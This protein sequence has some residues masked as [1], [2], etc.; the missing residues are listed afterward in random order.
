MISRSPSIIPALALSALASCVLASIA[1]AQEPS[2]DADVTV[3]ILDVTKV[4]EESREFNRQIDL[5]NQEAKKAQV[6]WDI[7]S[8]TTEHGEPDSKLTESTKK[9]LERRSSIYSDTYEE[10]RSIV[11][12]MAETYELRLVINVGGDIRNI[13]RNKGPQKQESVLERINQPVVFND[14]LD[15]TR[16]VIQ[17]MNEKTGLNAKRCDHCGQEIDVQ[18]KTTHTAD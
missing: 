7:D 11:K 8:L 3:V 18:K 14:K 10:V 2:K 1:P 9:F 16:M 12:E 15:L 5:L 17:R 13:G 4:F 6:E